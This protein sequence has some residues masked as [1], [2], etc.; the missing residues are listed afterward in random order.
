MIELCVDGAMADLRR[1]LTP[2]ELEIYEKYYKFF[3]RSNSTAI[4]CYT[5]ERIL[6]RS[7]N[8]RGVEE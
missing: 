3:K 2:E 7:L 5:S 6:Q 8:L 4:R 1:A